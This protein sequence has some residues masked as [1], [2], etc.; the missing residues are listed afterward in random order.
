M[1]V[2]I[3]WVVSLII[4]TYASVQIVRRL[5]QYGFAALVG[6][7]V[8]Y[9]GAAQILASKVIEFN[10]GFYQFF[11]PAAVFTYPFI[12]QV[13]DMINETYG[14]K[15]THIAILIAFASQILLV[16][17][18]AIANSLNPAPLF[19]WEDAWQLLFGLSIRVIAASW[20]SFLYV[21]TWMLLSLL[22]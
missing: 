5:P 21:P 2:W 22:N 4:V 6:F 10:L 9:L 11:A 12:A 18:I 16:A 8:I 15:N 3:Y 19:M 20:I 14:Q 7:C 1:L 17:F 13:I